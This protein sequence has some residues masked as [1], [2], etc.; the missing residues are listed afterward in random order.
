MTT[1]Q[2]RPGKGA[3]L[4]LNHEMLEF[5]METITDLWN[6]AGDGETEDFPTIDTLQDNE[7]GMEYLQDLSNSATRWKKSKDNFGTKLHKAL[8]WRSGEIRITVVLKDEKL[9]LDI[10]EWYDPDAAT[11][12]PWQK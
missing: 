2:L 1:E 11:G 3:H 9:K 12:Q 5:L 4:P 7:Q 8:P 10:R 6:A